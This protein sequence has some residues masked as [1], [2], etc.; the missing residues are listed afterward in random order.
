MKGI[1]CVKLRWGPHLCEEASQEASAAID[2]PASPQR[3]QASGCG[4]IEQHWAAHDRQNSLEMLEL[5]GEMETQDMPPD[6][7]FHPKRMECGEKML[8]SMTKQTSKVSASMEHFRSSK[9]GRSLVFERYV[10][11]LAKE[12]LSKSAEARADMQQW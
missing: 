4:E 6:L 3:L 5:D 7:C 10:C 8:Q 2:H 11:G 1:C 9:A 12:M